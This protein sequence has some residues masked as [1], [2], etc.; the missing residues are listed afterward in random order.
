METGF[1]KYTGDA[2]INFSFI[3]MRLLYKKGRQIEIGLRFLRKIA[4]PFYVK[5]IQ[6]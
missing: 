6:A 3:S 1:K 2:I 5:I 4:L